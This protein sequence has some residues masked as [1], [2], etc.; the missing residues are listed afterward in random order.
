RLDARDRVRR[1]GARGVV[2]AVAAGVSTVGLG[3]AARARPALV[4]TVGTQA[5]CERASAGG[6]GAA[7]LPGCV[8]LVDTV[9]GTVEAAVGGG[10]EKVGPAAV[11][12]DLGRADRKRGILRDDRPLRLVLVGIL[13][14]LARSRERGAAGDRQRRTTRDRNRGELVPTCGAL[15]LLSSQWSCMHGWRHFAPP[16]ATCHGPGPCRRTEMRSFPDIS[17]TSGRPGRGG[18]GP[19]GARRGTVG[20]LP[21]CRGSGSGVARAISTTSQARWRSPASVRPRTRRRRGA[22]R[23]RS[24]RRRP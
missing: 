2:R 22:P 3:G 13:H 4:P 24:E 16:C 1:V 14:L 5:D 7:V 20:S 11:L 15:Q 12:V 21:A 17:Q 18:L 10:L 9:V 23:P 19:R 8:A 6:V